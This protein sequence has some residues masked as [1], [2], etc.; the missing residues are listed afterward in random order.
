[1]DL[2]TTS[3]ALLALALGAL[4]TG[5]AS[6]GLAWRLR[7]RPGRGGSRRRNALLVREAALALVVPALPAASA[8]VAALAAAGWPSGAPER[9]VRWLPV[10]A[11]LP[12]TAGLLVLLRAARCERRGRRRAARGLA[13]LGA[14]AVAAGAVPF[15]G[16]TLTT[17][18]FDVE[19]R[20]SV[21]HEQ[22]LGTMT[23]ALGWI[24]FGAGG[25]VGMLAGLARKPRPG[26]VVAAVAGLAGALAV[27]GVVRGG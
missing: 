27:L 21:L 9:T 19:L 22:P 3:R 26:A 18:L 13:W 5:G 7:R 15:F 12:S 2:P 20:R 24:A 14:T 6:A 25:F 11:A 16:V 17:L 8:A 4:A 10:L 23:L 1:M